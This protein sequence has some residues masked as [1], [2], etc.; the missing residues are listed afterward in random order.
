MLTLLWGLSYYLNYE[1]NTKTRFIGPKTLLKLLLV[2][3]KSIIIIE[4]FK[5]ASSKKPS[6]KGSENKKFVRATMHG[7]KINKPVINFKKG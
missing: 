3:D 6:L 2:I 1:T 4:T 7:F 5:S